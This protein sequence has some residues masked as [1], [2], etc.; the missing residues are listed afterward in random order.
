MAE[1]PADIH[2]I[3][4]ATGAG[5]STYAERL[6]QHIDGVRMSID[7]WLFRL[8]FADAPPEL[9]YDFFYE[10]V[11]RNTLQMRKLAHQLIRLR[12][13]VIFDCGFTNKVERQIFYDWAA[14]Y[15]YSTQ[16]HFVDTATDLRWQRTQVRNAQ[17]GPTFMFEVTR[18]MFDF[19]ESI[20][21]A[22]D[23]DEM[24]RHRGI[25]QKT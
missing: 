12:T 2:L 10:R 15:G 23:A 13:P 17:K 14:K 11:Q 20:W 21:Q 16:L 24:A 6:A 8:H 22:P 9:S 4:G 5:K 7:E 1:A 25:A 18:Q 19:I 3:C